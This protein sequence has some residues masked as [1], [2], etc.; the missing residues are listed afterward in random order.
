MA[1]DA[2][3]GV[4][5]E[6]FY[7]ECDLLLYATGILNKFKWPEITGIENFKGRLV[8][9]AHWPEDYQAEQWKQDRV[10][11]IGSGASSVQTVPGMQPYVKH[12]DVFVRTGVWFVQVANNYGSNYEY[13]EEQKREFKEHPETLV[14][15]AKDIENQMNGKWGVYYAGTEK[16]KAARELFRKR[17][18]EFIKDER[19][20]KGFTPKFELGCR[21]VTPGD[22]YMQAI[23]EPNVDIHFTHAQ[24]ITEK[25]IIGGDGIE[26]EVDTI[27]CAT[28]F[29][30][31]YRPGFPLVGLNGIEL[32]KKWENAPEGYLGLGSA[33]MPNFI[34]FLGPT[35]PVTNGSIAGPVQAVAKYAV[36]IVHKM[37]RDNIKYWVPKQHVVD[38]FN[39]HAQE[40]YKHSVWKDSCRYWYKNN[41]T[42]RVNAVWPGSALHYMDTISVPRYE[43]F[44]IEYHN[45]N[46]W[47][48]LGMGFTLDSIN[49]NWSPTVSIENLDPKWLESAGVKVPDQLRK[50]NPSSTKVKG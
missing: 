23:Q 31:T 11:V 2:I 49:E 10:A 39:D 36:Q 50:E 34:M 18:A 21:R 13:T 19:L 7:D 25:G 24:T 33:D 40:W 20:L 17:V 41:D 16:Q 9:T 43:D 35:W 44:A 4:Q 46:M 47:G 38:Q 14:A 8:H 45:N 6:I 30:V 32:G 29:D 3:L 5:G 1:A 26:R 42:G 15:H 12:M 48:F 28:G 22:P 37:Q 27:V